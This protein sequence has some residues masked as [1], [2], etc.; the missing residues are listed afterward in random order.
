MPIHRESHPEDVDLKPGTTK[1]EIVVFLYQ[2]LE[3]AYT[4]SEVAEELDIP[5]GTA[6]TTLR[7]LHNRGYVGRMED[8]YY[9]GLD[10]RDD[11]RRYPRS[12]AETEAM[13][14]T[15]PDTT[16]APDPEPS[17]VAD[18]SSVDDTALESELDNLEGEFDV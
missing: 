17:Q 3:F 5:N 4:P 11:L 13:F 9:H 6:T 8:G 15:H 7:R 18:A 10:D 2:N 16:A 12:V 14:A 1:S